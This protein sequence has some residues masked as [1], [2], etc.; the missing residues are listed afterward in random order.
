MSKITFPKV[1]RI[2]PASQCNL[3][4]SHYPTDTV[5]MDRGVMSESIFNLILNEIK[6]NIDSIEI[7]VLYRGGEPLLKLLFYVIV[8]KIKNIKPSIF[9]KSMTDG[10]TLNRSNSIRLVKS[11]RKLVDIH[12]IQTSTS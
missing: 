11:R 12:V 8:A 7:V 9:I 6:N 4:F 5:C 1:T 3:A 10:M 2:E